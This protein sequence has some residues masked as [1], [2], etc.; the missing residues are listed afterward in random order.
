MT[1]TY[2]RILFG[3]VEFTGSDFVEARL[4]EEFNPLAITLPINVLEFSVFSNDVDFSIIN[5][6]GDFETLA[7]IRPMSVYE[8]RGEEQIYLGQYYL[9][10]WKNK[11]ENVK[12]FTAYDVLGLL[13][14]L[15]Y[16]GG[17]W[18]TAVTV[19][20][21]VAGV[22]D[23]I[24][25]SYEIDPDVA[26]IEL[27]G[28]L[29]ISNYREALQQIAFAAGAYVLSARR[30][31]LVIGKLSQASIDL[32][33]I[34]TGVAKSGQSRVYQVRWRPT[35]TFVYT[36]GG[37]VTRGYRAG[38]AKTGQSRNWGKR[39][40]PSQW[41]GVKPI[42]E[43]ESSEQGSRS[44][45]LRP[46][47]TGVE[48]VAH[49]IVEGTGSMELLNQAM[50]AGT[51]E[52]HFQQPMHDLTISGATITESGANY[53]ILEVASA[54]TVVLSGLV[55]VSSDTVYGQYLAAV[56]GRKDN[57]IKIEDA[58]LVNSG[59]GGDVC[60]A[61]FNYY[62]QRYL[63][64]MKLFSPSSYVEVGATVD[65]ET[66]YSNR[67]FGVVERMETNLTGGNVADTEVVGIIK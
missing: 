51:H 43:I 21:L 58:T 7:T 48:V 37:V 56:D 17:M 32:S 9:E 41:E 63:Q 54:G 49:D 27:S 20:E 45:N 11:S 62:Q 22:L 42:V 64:Q 67:L 34:R 44:V 35:Q 60:T 55:Y 15:T 40:R 46:Q 61:V 29:P 13:D 25:V 14:R 53:A 52:I 10:D 6:S 66:L 19:G 57:I 26:A 31:A 8:V 2:P 24:G 12:Q 47:V 59:N 23:D 39:W 65:L 36:S 4:T 38:V 5:P 16:R 28:W 50:P 1:R 33:G 3:S 30:D 18:L